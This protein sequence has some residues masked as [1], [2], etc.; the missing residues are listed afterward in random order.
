MCCIYIKY[1]YFL[2][3]HI[4]LWFIFCLAK[5]IRHIKYVSD[6]EYMAVI[7]LVFDIN[8]IRASL[9]ISYAKPES[10]RNHLIESVYESVY[11]VNCSL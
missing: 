5:H 9:N 6:T 8:N 1:I 4:Y 11:K 10:Q 2:F 7:K 3:L